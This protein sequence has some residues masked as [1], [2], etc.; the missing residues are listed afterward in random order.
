MTWSRIARRIR[1]P[2][3][4]VFAGFY[5]WRARPTWTS[6]AV[7]ALVAALGIYLRAM[8]SGH[9]K[10]NEELTTTGPYAH[11]RNPLYLGSIVLAI[12]FTIA[13]REVWIAVAVVALFAVIYVPVIRSEE[14]FLRQRFPEFGIYAAR[15]PRL[16][17]RTNFFRQTRAD[18]SKDL[19]WKHREYNALIGAIAV[20]VA[21]V[22]KLIWFPG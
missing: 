5:L 12:G 9:V 13:A 21:L 11:V 22:V 17:P 3:G 2:L 16:L 8:A 15:V 6:T 14:A 1:V 20:L 18:F 19:Y 10:K 4:F 7:G